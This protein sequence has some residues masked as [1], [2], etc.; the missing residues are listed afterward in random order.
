MKTKYIVHIVVVGVI[1]GDVEVIPPFF[2][3]DGFIL[4]TETYIKPL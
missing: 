1:P 2:F 3:L 4:N